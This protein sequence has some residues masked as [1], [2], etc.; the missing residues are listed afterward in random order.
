[1]PA[2][3]KYFLIHKWIDLSVFFMNKLE[4]IMR[5]SDQVTDAFMLLAK[6]V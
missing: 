2:S 5:E 4:T 3:D 6:F 1:M